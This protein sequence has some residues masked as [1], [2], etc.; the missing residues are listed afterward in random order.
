MVA[1]S[2]YECIYIVYVYIIYIYINFK[3]H[4]YIYI[5]VSDIFDSLHSC[6]LPNYLRK[7][8]FFCGVLLPFVR[9]AEIRHI[10]VLF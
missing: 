3:I 9:K 6:L 5:Y 2:N 1:L 10:I 8:L 7:I 4:L